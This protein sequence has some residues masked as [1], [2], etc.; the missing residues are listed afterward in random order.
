M[1][2]PEASPKAL[3]ATIPKAT[4]IRIRTEILLESVP[5]TIGGCKILIRILF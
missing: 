2:L 1:R 4:E 3:E 5:V